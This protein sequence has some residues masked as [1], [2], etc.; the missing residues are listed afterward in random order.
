MFPY[1]R[2]CRTDDEVKD[3]INE[4]ETERRNIDVLT[5]GAVINSTTSPRA[6]FWAVPISSPAGR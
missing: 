1:Y 3:A 2:L 5:D 6:R 4:I